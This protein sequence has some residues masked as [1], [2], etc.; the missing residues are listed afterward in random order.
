[1]SYFN[2]GDALHGFV[3]ALLR[4]PAEPRLR[5]DPRSE[6]AAVIWPYTPIG[7]IVNLTG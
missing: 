4:L 3:R 2:G 6:A 5:R 7:T 1:M